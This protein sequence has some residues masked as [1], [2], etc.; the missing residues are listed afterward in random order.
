MPKTSS[1]LFAQGRAVGWVEHEYEDAVTTEFV[2][3]ADVH[4][5]TAVFS[6]LHASSMNSV[7]SK[8]VPGYT[9]PGGGGGGLL[10]AWKRCTSTS[11]RR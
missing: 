4:I 3:R 2:Q 1:S 8:E 7:H 9:G 6:T 11:R 5:H 10:L